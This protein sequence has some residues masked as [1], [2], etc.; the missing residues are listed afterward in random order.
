MELPPGLRGLADHQL[1]VVTRRQLLDSGVEAGAVRWR[2]GRTW[3]LLLPGVVLLEPSFPSTPQRL[4]AALLLAGPDSWLSGATAAGLHGLPGAPDDP[5][6]HVLVPAPRRP[7]EVAWVSIRRTHL[8]DERLVERGP[9][10]WSCAARA[11]VDAAADAP[12]ASATRS[13]VIAAV[14]D[15]RVRLD[16]VQHWVEARRPNGRLVLRQAVREA[17]A[18]AWSLPEADLLR[19]IRTSHVLPEPWPN[20]GLVDGAGHRLTTPDVWFDDV[21]MAVMVHSRRFHAATLDWDHTVDRDSDLGACRIAVVG[22][23]PSSIER[24]PAQVLDRIESTY[25]SARALGTETRRDGDPTR[26]APPRRLNRSARPRC[27]VG[28]GSGQGQCRVGTGSVQGRCTV[29]SQLR[30]RVLLSEQ[31]Q[32]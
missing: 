27:R 26:G 2:L 4:V 30:S 16:D 15:R 25:L 5:T 3:R 23:T 22:V 7:R 1:G 31:H 6:V 9:L 24:R 18:G 11:L 12:T 28:A 8:I 32:P 21:A 13:M 10:R 19:L 17:A 20:P 14:Q 29:T